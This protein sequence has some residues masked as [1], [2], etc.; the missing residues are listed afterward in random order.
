MARKDLQALLLGLGLDSKDGHV[1]MTRG[2][3]YRL[4]GGSKETHDRMQET[5]E[6][7]NE[8]LNKRHKRIEDLDRD[9]F[10]DIA[11]TADPRFSPDD[12]Q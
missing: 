2:E 7:F 10:L 5:A 11:R 9:E 4:F 6:R 8:E 12:K 1:R 3:N